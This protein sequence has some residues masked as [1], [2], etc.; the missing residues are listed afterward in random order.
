MKAL[1]IDMYDEN[2]IMKYKQAGDNMLEQLL[3]KAYDKV[4]KTY[5]EM[6]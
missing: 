2:T 3:V 1:G 6:D 5:M 4:L